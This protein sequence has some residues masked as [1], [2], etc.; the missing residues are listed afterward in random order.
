MNLLLY[1]NKD[2]FTWD[3]S[4]FTLP[5][6]KGIFLEFGNGLDSV[7]ELLEGASI[8]EALDLVIDRFGVDRVAVQVTPGLVAAA[9][10]Q[11]AANQASGTSACLTFYWTP[12]P[13]HG[14]SRILK[15][16]K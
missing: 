10:Q 1:G 5:D 2:G 13:T 3:G 7:E 16:E 8:G 4:L 11:L 15:G 9:A 14:A 6:G 12:G